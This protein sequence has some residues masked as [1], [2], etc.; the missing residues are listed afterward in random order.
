MMTLAQFDIDR[1]E[2]IVAILVLVL[3]PLLGSLG[4]TLRKKSGLEPGAEDEDEVLG[5]EIILLPPAKTSRPA[6][7]ARPLPPA[8]AGQPIRR[9]DRPP[10]LPPPL[11]RPARLT[12]PPPPAR[13]VAPRVPP[14]VPRRGVRVPP[15][16]PPA[17]R[18]AE[19]SRESRAWEARQPASLVDAI[20]A[21]EAALRA[22]GQAPPER[23]AVL[24]P[25]DRDELRKAII[26]SE[27]LRPPLA[28]RSPG[29]EL[30]D[31]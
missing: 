26:L 13:P 28:L 16:A 2:N 19:V 23:V 4:K 14:A 31:A 27:L 21:S 29:T 30:W 1:W 9:T 5:E 3:L 18:P 20:R 10:L 8:G 11:R 17:L 25:L 24:G 12:P 15:G 7:S 6:P 22:A